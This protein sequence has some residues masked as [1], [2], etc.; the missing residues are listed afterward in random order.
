M[1]A[2]VSVRGGQVDTER[3]SGTPAVQCDLRAQR[4][5]QLWRPLDEGARQFLEAQTVQQ[6]IRARNGE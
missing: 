5:A 1:H 4:V 3:E 6:E 2:Q